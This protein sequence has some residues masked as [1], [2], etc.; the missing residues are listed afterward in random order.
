MRARIGFLLAFLLASSLALAGTSINGDGGGGSGG[1]V[2]SA[3]VC[4]LSGGT[5]CTMTGSTVYSGVTSDITTGTNEALSLS[6]NGTGD[7]IMDTDQIATNEATGLAFDMVTTTPT[8]TIFYN[9]RPSNYCTGGGSRIL[10]AGPPGTEAL[11]VLCDSTVRILGA[12]NLTL[13]SAGNTIRSYFGGDAD[14]ADAATWLGSGATAGGFRT[15][16]AGTGAQMGSKGD[17]AATAVVASIA[18]GISS[19]AAGA[20][21]W[22]FKGGGAATVAVQAGISE[23]TATLNTTTPTSSYVEFNC[24]SST[25][26]NY[27]PGETSSEDG[28]FFMLTNVG[29]A[30]VVVTDNSGKVV[31]RGSPQIVGVNEQLLCGYS[32]GLWHCM[33]GDSGSD[34]GVNAQTGTTYTLAATD[35]NKT[36]TLSNGSAITVTLPSGLPT[37]CAMVLVQIGAGQVTISPSSTTMNNR[38][39]HTKLAGQY[40]TASLKQYTSNVYVLAGDTAP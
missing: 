6:P 37:N 5:D 31:V 21:L 7:V 12:A 25:F 30:P 33:A 32:G 20:A 26:C 36:V 11:G 39:S 16:A 14:D 38:L 27:E 24:T 35:C 8:P 13:N 9:I 40:A 19:T 29:S 18:D 2:A 10:S 28:D 23:S 1:G 3:L 22:K 4:L 15:N 34:A 17:I